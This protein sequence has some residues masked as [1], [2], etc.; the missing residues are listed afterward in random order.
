MPPPDMPKSNG[1]VK[2]AIEAPLHPMDCT[3]IIVGAVRDGRS[4]INDMYTRDRS[5]P[6]IDTWFD[7]EESL[8]AAYGIEQ[9]GRTIVSFRRKIAEIEPS[10][11]PLGPDK[12]FVIWAKGQEPNQYRHSVKS[13][14]ETGKIKDKDFYRVDQLKY[15]GSINRGVYPIEFVA[16]ELMP[17]RGRPFMIRRPKPTTTETPLVAKNVDQRIEVAQES[18]PISKPQPAVVPEPHPAQPP[19]PGPQPQLQ[20]QPPL[21][22][23]PQPEP[24]PE[25]EPK[26]RAEPEPEPAPKLDNSVETEAEPVPV[27]VV[28]HRH[29]IPVIEQEPKQNSIVSAEGSSIVRHEDYESSSSAVRFA[30]LA[31]SF[32]F[33]VCSLPFL[34]L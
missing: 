23:Q 33:L 22:P 12:M 18:R 6:L 27:V 10:D 24:Q 13:A 30:G 14:I 20:H 25:P 5:T 34:T 19:Q 16:K 26:P 7:G 1:F 32:L 8:S 17:Q 21:Q 9:D 15:H 3:D 11:H 4:R 29:S 31:K 2:S 28:P